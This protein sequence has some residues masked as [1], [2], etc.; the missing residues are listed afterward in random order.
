MLGVLKAGLFIFAFEHRGNSLRLQRQNTEP[1][2]HFKQ[3]KLTERKEQYLFL[4]PK[5][6]DQ[7]YGGG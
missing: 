3:A 7:A 4:K 5:K 6:D 1:G 2:Q